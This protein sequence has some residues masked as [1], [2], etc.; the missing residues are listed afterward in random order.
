VREDDKK[1]IDEHYNRTCRR[2]GEHAS[3]FHVNF[4]ILPTVLREGNRL[5]KR[6][7]Q[8]TDKIAMDQT[9]PIINKIK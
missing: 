4:I 1:K 3:M 2:A 8:P 5:Q 7:I 9:S 6:K